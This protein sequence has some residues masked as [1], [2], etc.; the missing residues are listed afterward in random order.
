MKSN[1][2]NKHR[3]KVIKGSLFGSG[4]INNKYKQKKTSET[5][6]VYAALFG[7]GISI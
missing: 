7:N 3:N 5:E 4:E 1:Y 6:I 2:L